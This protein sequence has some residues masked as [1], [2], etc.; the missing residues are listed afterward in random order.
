MAS[1][2]RVA[3]ATRSLGN[4]EN[5]QFECAKVIHETLLVPL[6]MYGSEKMLWKEEGRSI[7]RTVHMD[8]VRGWLG[9][10]RMDR[11]PNARVRELCGVID[12][13]VIWWFGHVERME[14]D[15]IAK[16][17]Y[18]GEGAGSCSVG[19][20]RKRWIDTMKDSLRKR[21]GYQAG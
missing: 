10:K 16:R 5:F 17:V 21:F 8:N 11:V 2:R 12:E 13:C 15:K 9:I 3:G 20:P 19:R 4:V 1:G 18:V 6:L 7:I 14:N